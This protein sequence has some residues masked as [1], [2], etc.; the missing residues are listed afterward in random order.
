MEQLL[1]KGT[2]YGHTYNISVLPAENYLKAQCKLNSNKI[3]N[4]AITVR[5]K[6]EICSYINKN[7]IDFSNSKIIP[8]N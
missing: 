3:V 5:Y 4:R 1:I 7:K 6:G 8:N 2:K